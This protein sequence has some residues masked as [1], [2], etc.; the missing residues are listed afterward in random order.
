MIPRRVKRSREKGLLEVIPASLGPPRS[1]RNRFKRVLG[2][3]PKVRIDEGLK[4]TVDWL[5]TTGRLPT[6]V[7]GR[8]QRQ[9]ASV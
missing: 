2:H 5:A 7:T 9:A 6:D 1:P 8:L 3:A 4:R